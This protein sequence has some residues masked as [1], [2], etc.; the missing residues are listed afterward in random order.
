MKRIVVGFDGREGG[1]DALALGRALATEGTEIGVGIALP[2]EPIHGIDTHGY[3]VALTKHFD[4]LFDAV[5]REMG[6]T[7]FT[8]HE[9][10]NSSPT[11]ALLE[12]AA[13]EQAELIVLGSSHHGRVGRVYPGSV[14]EQMMSGAETAVAVAPRGFADSKKRSISVIGVAFDGSHESNLAL[15][16]A[17]RLRE[18]LGGS[19]KLITVVHRSTLRSQEWQDIAIDRVRGAGEIESVLDQGDP[20]A[21]LESR[22]AELDLL[23]I[24][25]RGYGPIRRVLL[26]GV[27]TKVMRSATCPVMIVPRAGAGNLPAGAEEAGN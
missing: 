11:Q 1:R 2:Y 17:N 26:G 21:V 25:S 22:S 12:L 7:P 4:V 20:A 15:L 10:R 23:V 24:G 8:R 5:R 14:G 3:D 6:E 19:L 18:R 9:L 27:S 16:A 13:A